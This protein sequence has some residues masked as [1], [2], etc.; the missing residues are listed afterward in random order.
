[1]QRVSTL[2]AAGVL[3]LGA[4]VANGAAAQELPTAVSLFAVHAINGLDLG[5]ESED[6]TTVDVLVAPPE[7]SGEP[8]CVPEFGFGDVL[9]PVEIEV[10]EVP[11]DYTVSIFLPDADVECEGTPVA[12]ADVPVSAL[13]G[14]V[15]VVAGLDVGKTPFVESF[16][17]DASPL[18]AGSSRIS[19]VH[20]AVA[21]EVGIRIRDNDSRE[22]VG[23]GSIENGESTLPL[24]LPEGSYRSFVSV[25]D[26]V[27]ETTTTITAKNFDLAAGIIGVGVL[28][29]SEE[30]DT[31]EVIRVEIEEEEEQ[32]PPETPA[33]DT[34]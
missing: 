6:A 26:P 32:T 34:Q 21:P 16:P 5:L 12:S 4:A 14:T 11:E 1:M 9:G 10:P 13:G 8:T 18:E 25:T 33:N 30:N 31:A 23:G 19:V 17:V 28:A 29:G 7:G 24:T 15:L 3:V 20:A 27:D 2:T 22:F